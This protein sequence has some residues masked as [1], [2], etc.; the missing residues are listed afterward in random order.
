MKKITVFIFALILSSSFAFSMSYRGDVSSAPQKE[1]AGQQADSNKTDLIKTAIREIYKGDFTAAEKIIKQTDGN[2]SDSAAILE[3]ISQYNQIQQSRRQAKRQ[4]YEK[5]LAE[6]EKFSIRRPKDKAQAETNEPNVVDVFAV[7]VRLQEAADGNDKTKILDDAFVKDTIARAQK[8]AAEYEAKGEWVDALLYCYSW[9]T[10]IDENNKVYS[11]KKEQLEERAIVKASLQDSPCETSTERYEKVKPEMFIRSLDVLEYSYVEPFYYSGMTDKALKRCRYLAEV[12]SL[13]NSFDANSFKIEFARDKMPKFI[14]GLSSL[15]KEYKREVVSL[16]KD[17]FVKLF[18]HILALNSAT[19]KLPEEIIV[20]HFADS[21]LS[22][23]DPHTMIVWP[24]QVEDFEKNM[25][26][27]FTGIGVEIS[28][29]DGLLKA[30]SLVPDTPAYN[31]GLD[32]GD[33]IE[34]V[35]GES[36]KAMSI[37][38]AVSKITGPAGT[39]VLLSVRRPG[40]ETTRDIEITRAKIIVPTTRGWCRDDSGNWLYFA[41][42]KDKVG[43]VRVTQFSANTASDL[44]SVIIQLEGS[45]MGAL[46]IDLRYNSGGYLQS[47][48]DIVDLFVEKGTIVSTQ[49]RVGLPTW[50]AARK[51]GTHPNYPLVILI[52]SGSASASEIV[53]GA[54]ADETFSRAVLVGEQ[55]YG[56]GSVQT[57]TS[58]PGEGAQLKYTMAYYHLPSDQRVNDRWAMEKLGKKNWGIMPGVKIELTSDEI[59]KMLDME[60]DNDILA[61]ANHDENKKKLTRHNLAETL[62]ADSQ[63]AV[64]VLVAKTKLIELGL[65]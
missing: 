17:Q 29:R 43:Y 6:L 32:A 56:K 65:K 58:Y 24:K 36:T 34:A 40:E 26:N 35:N 2:N 50:E 30:V 37:N 60:R 44:D 46:I 18:R 21:C 13:S 22:T 38:C 47:A 41:D 10:V 39:K 28:K 64:A 14:A 19:M 63:L 8:I 15:E 31:S 12:L 45:G 4:T 7:I 55:S 59:K 16:S 23:L 3:V 57:I 20:W 9:L 53:A 25:T 33:I 52:N 54:L 61:A 49:P 48:A 42:D 5:K 51:R 62:E 27:E 1:A 11:D